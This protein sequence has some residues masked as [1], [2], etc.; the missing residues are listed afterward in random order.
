MSV[1]SNPQLWVTPVCCSYDPDVNKLML[2]VERWMSMSSSTSP[3]TPS[4]DH[5]P[6]SKVEWPMASLCERLPDAQV[7]LVGKEEAEEC[8]SESIPDT[9]SPAEV[10]KERIKIFGAE[11]ASTPVLRRSRRSSTR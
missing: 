4:K 11:H 9:L 2:V 7:G 3:T 10:E 6:S 1:H 5:V 8:V